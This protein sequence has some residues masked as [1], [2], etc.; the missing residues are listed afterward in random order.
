MIVVRPWRSILVLEDDEDQLGTWKAEIQEFNEDDGRPFRIALRTASNLTEAR[1]IL[2][3]CYLNAAIVDLR[4]PS[5][6]DGPN[7][8]D[9]GNIAVKQIIETIA[10]PTAIFSG[11]PGEV[12]G[13]VANT[14]VRTFPKEAGQLKEIVDWLCQHAPLMTAVTDVSLDIRRETARVFEGMIWRRWDQTRDL[15]L[16]AEVLRQVV[17]RQV[18]AHIAEQLSLPLNNAP[19]YHP[20]EFYFEP[21]LRQD[22]MH[23]GD[24]LLV[25]EEVYVILTP[26]CDM[27][28]EYPEKVLLAKRREIIG[29]KKFPK[30]KKDQYS[31][32]GHAIKSHFLPPC[33]DKGP[34]IVD[35]KFLITKDGPA[36]H[37]LLPLR[38]ASIAAQFVPNLIQRFS[39]FMGRIGQPEVEI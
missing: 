6:P 1:T 38:F 4:I 8:A 18:V 33:G 39:T 23:T 36:F 14:P 10:G 19:P 3:K 30:S 15:Q 20:F 11:H 5:G 17:T 22:R 26:Q 37:E 2:Q 25:D 32:Q 7:T 35:F 16:S 21:P 12:A 27:V 9:S 24:L 13:F 28:R 29:W 34:W 31:R